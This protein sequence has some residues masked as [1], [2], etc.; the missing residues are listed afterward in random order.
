MNGYYPEGLEEASLPGLAALKRAK[1]YGTILEAPVTRC[2][3]KMNLHIALDGAVGIIPK[4]EVVL[5]IGNESIKDIAILTRVGKRV[6]FH[7]KEMIEEGG[8]PRFILS[9][10]SAQRECLQMKVKHLYP[11]DVI[12]TRITH[13][14]P[15]GIFLDI[16]CGLI[17]LLPIDAISVSRITHPKH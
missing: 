11:G 15:F 13:I 2:D 8:E 6:C 7:V 5:P 12:E 9:R 16:G 17:S 10:R 1:E 14:E 3:G 4:E